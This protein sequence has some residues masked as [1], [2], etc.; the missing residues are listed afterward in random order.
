MRSAALLIVVLALAAVTGLAVAALAGERPQ[1]F[2]LGVARSTAVELPPGETVC[3]TPVTVP[4][5]GAFEGVTLAVGTEGRPGP[6]LDLVVR[7]VEP[8]QPNSRRGA[9]LGRS[10]LAAGYPDVDRAPEQTLWLRRVRDD[11]SVA[12]CFANGGGR[13][14]FIYGDADAAARSST[15]YLAD[16]PTGADLALDFERREPRTLASL[17]P[18]MID[19]AAL[20]RAHWIGAWTYWVLAALVLIGVPALLVAAMRATLRDTA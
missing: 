2:T 20:F 13:R 10:S 12:I 16:A 15:A 9:V 1:A 17:I 6:A 3:Q 5:D 8:D 7:E 4:E 19:R 14:A 11:S 18:A